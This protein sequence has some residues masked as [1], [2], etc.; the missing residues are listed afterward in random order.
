MEKGGKE[1]KLRIAIINPDKCKPKKCH[2]ECKK[3]CPINKGGKLCIEVLPTDKIAKIAENLC[4]GCGLCVKKCPFNA[5]RI[6]NLP[7]NL[8]KE[9]THRYGQNAFKLHRLP[10][11]QLSQVL[12]LVGTNGIGKTTALLVLSGELK[13]N[14]G[15]YNEPPD[16]NEILKHFKGSELYNYFKKYLDSEL[17][18]TYKVQH[19]DAI[20]KNAKGT[21][22][23]LFLRKDKEGKRTAE[24]AELL[25]LTALM[26][27]NI[28]T[29]S[30][31]ELQR[32]AI[33]FSCIQETEVYMFD[34]PTSYLDVK[35]RLNAANAIRS[36]SRVDNYIICVEHDLSVL[37]YLSD[38]VCVLYGVPAAYGVVTLP[39]GVREGINVFLEGFIPTENMRFRDFSLSFKIADNTDIVLS[40]KEHTYKYPK[41]TKTLQDFTLTVEGG[42]FSN[43]EIVVLLGENGTGKTTL[44]RMLSGDKKCPPNEKEFEIPELAVS[45]KPQTIAPKYPGTVIE[46]LQDKLKE[47]IT[48]QSFISEV[49]KPLGV[50]TLYDNEVQKLS[51]GE[52]Q[53]VALV[54]ALGKK[55]NVYLIDEPSAYLDSEQRIIAAKVMKRFVLNA[56]KSAFVVEHD[57]I[58][59]TYMAD[60]V[61]VY[62][63]IP[64]VN[65]TAT[66]PRPMIEGMNAFLKMMNITFRRDNETY[67]P[68]I[69]K[70][71]SVK[72][73]EQKEKGIYFYYE[74]L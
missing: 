56:N 67:R 1:E 22:R 69:N 51:G 30:G 74:N 62:E 65:T 58:M 66:A 60:R 28:E 73:K 4:I 17:T 5:I 48:H 46:L 24:Y 23:E 12:G 41:M 10:Y 9:T 57:F 36:L 64:A 39:Y 54:L 33:A 37:D 6:I 26:D 27:R 52:L 16:W 47:V 68:R 70:L 63:G 15:R 53:R 34:E 19:V 50:Q 44:V 61:I 29:L 8:E 18:V 25:G 40:N 31:G 11:P 2:L 72:D 38:T 7:K 45:Y 35:Q 55:A 43:C 20:R 14:F 21:I 13:P 42:A 71:N 3:I 32:F 49:V 59:A